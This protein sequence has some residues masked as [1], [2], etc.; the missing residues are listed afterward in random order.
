MSMTVTLRDDQTQQVATYRVG[1]GDGFNL[2]IFPLP[3]PAGPA[4]DGR[5]MVVQSTGPVLAQHIT[6]L[7]V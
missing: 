3:T 5:F 1:N 4:R 2:M 7:G 6:E